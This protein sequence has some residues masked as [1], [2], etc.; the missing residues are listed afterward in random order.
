MDLI[1]ST[2]ADISE[3][4]LGMWMLFGDFLTDDFIFPL[5]FTFSLTLRL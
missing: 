2:I 5:F 4:L 3:C 1:I